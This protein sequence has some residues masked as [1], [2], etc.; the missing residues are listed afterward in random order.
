VEEAVTKKY[1]IA[2][3]A[4]DAFKAIHEEH[5]QLIQNQKR[6]TRR[7]SISTN[8]VSQDPQVYK[9]RRVKKKILRGKKKHWPSFA[10]R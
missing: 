2:F 5:S 8:W 3:E 1:E 4:M 7:V 10:N 6:K 9:Y